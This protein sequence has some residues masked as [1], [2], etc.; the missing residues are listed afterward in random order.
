M[1]AALDD[2]MREM[3]NPDFKRVL[4]VAVSELRG[5]G[6]GGSG[7]GGAGQAPTG[8]AAAVGPTG[9]FIGSLLSSGSDAAGVAELSTT[10][11]MLQRLASELESSPTSAAGGPTGGGTAAAADSVPASGPTAPA[12]AAALADGVMARMVSEFER[13][14]SADDFGGAVDGMMRQLLSRDLMYA[15][16][17][18]ISEAVSGS[19][20]RCMRVGVAWVSAPAV[21][22]CRVIHQRRSCE[23]HRL[24]RHVIYRYDGHSPATAMQYPAWLA[25]HAPPRLSQSEYEAAGRQYRLFQSITA[26]YETDPDN[27][28]RLLEL[29]Q[30]LQESGGPPREIIAAIAPGLELSEDGLP[31][32]PGMMG[33]ATDALGDGGSLQQQCVIA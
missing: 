25:A 3:R 7:A 16:M 21:A 33:G 11:E 29:L 10:L 5:G 31:M 18:Q 17:V 12:A 13:M 23:A 6:G 9:A 26:V 32:L 20:Q 24:I 4:D 14:G 15:P 1:A 28:P 30:Q 19:R 27:F 22:V 8:E 2:L